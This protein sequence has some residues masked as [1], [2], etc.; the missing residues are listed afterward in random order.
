MKIKPIYFLVKVKMFP[1]NFMNNFKTKCNIHHLKHP[2]MT[3]TVDS[4]LN[5]RIFK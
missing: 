5:N 1:S 3:F 4:I 2:S